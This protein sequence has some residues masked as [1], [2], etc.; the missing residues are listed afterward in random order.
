MLAMAKRRAVNIPTPAQIK[1]FRER[2]GKPIEDLSEAVGVGVRTWF[3]WEAGTR[4]PSRS[5][6][7]LLSQLIGKS[8]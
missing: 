6:A 3:H 4:R 8:V 5:A 1:A 2:S 7:I